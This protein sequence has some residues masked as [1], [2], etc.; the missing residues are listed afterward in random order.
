MYNQINLTHHIVHQQL[1]NNVYCIT[2]KESHEDHV[3]MF[4]LTDFSDVALETLDYFLNKNNKIVIRWRLIIVKTTLYL[5]VFLSTV[6]QTSHSNS[7]TVS[8]MED[9]YNSLTKT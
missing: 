4:F 5:S 7:G 2:V 8:R 6:P 3:T 1:T 9:L